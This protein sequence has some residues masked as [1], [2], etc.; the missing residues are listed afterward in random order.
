MK[1]LVIAENEEILNEITISLPDDRTE[2]DLND[3]IEGV[4]DD[5]FDVEHE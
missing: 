5:F 1:V 3:E 4:L 2:E